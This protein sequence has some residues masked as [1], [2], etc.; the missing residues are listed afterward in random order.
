MFLDHLSQR[1][2][3][4]Y[5]DHFLSGVV[6]CSNYSHIGLHERYF[7]GCISVTTYDNDLKLHSYLKACQTVMLDNFCM[8]LV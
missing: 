4:S 1:L 3:V 8:N 7:H 5:S 6:D 2:N